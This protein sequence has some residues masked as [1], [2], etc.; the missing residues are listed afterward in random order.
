MLREPEVHHRHV[1]LLTGAVD[2]LDIDGLAS[3]LAAALDHP[4]TGVHM[5]HAQSVEQVLAPVGLPP[6]VEQHIETMARLHRAHRYER[7]DR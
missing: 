3:H 5:P 4:V 2:L 6:H 1:Y 7:S